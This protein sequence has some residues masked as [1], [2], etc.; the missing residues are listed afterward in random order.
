MEEKKIL[1]TKIEFNVNIRDQKKIL[2]N[3]VYNNMC[4]N[5]KANVFYLSPSISHAPFSSHIVLSIK[6][7]SL[8]YLSFHFPTIC[9]PEN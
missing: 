2:A 1:W 5:D 6:P 3:P 7:Y 9:V 8:P 4:H